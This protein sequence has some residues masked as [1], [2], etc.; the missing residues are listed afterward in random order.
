MSRFSSS[1]HHRF[2]FA[3]YRGGCGRQRGKR[4]SEMEDWWSEIDSAV[5]G[6]LQ[7]RG[8]VPP[9]EIGRRLGVSEAAVV[10]VIAALARE[11]KVRISAVALSETTVSG[12]TRA[13]R[14]RTSRRTTRQ[15]GGMLWR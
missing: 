11:G 15:R 3:G 9:A 6:C 13:G 12:K 4:G 5:I 8:E 14:L 2:T 7:G 1:S 10:S